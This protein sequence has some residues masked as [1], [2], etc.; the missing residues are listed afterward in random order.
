[1]SRSGTS[2][3]VLVSGTR[4]FGAARLAR[5]LHQ[6]AAELDL[7]LRTGVCCAPLRAESILVD[8]AGTRWESARWPLDAAQAGVTELQPA[9]REL[10]AL[11]ELLLGQ[12]P[13]CIEDSLLPAGRGPT[14]R[15][16]DQPL[17][18]AWRRTLGAIARRCSSPGAYRSA[19][20]LVRD[21]D[22]LS[23]VSQRIVAR[24]QKPPRVY[25]CQP[26]PAQQHAAL[27]KVMLR[28]A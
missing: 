26:R 25:L 23:G 8:Q 5:L 19:A 21:L 24:R 4:S 28:C 3:S 18:N 2:L 11:M 10:G 16:A 22:K 15:R 13:L 1:M 27:P 12:V 6:L 17:L 9:L 20:E 14:L 7:A